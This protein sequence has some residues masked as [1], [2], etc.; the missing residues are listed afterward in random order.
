M[1]KLKEGNVSQEG[2]KEDYIERMYKTLEGGEVTPEFITELVDDFS[3]LYIAGTDTSSIE[4]FMLLYYC[5]SNPKC[6]EKLREEVDEFIK[7]DEDIRED[8]IKKMR[9]LDGVFAETTRMHSPAIGVFPRCVTKDYFMKEVQIKKDT[10]VNASF[11]GTQYNPRIY[12]EPF[13]FRPERWISADGAKLSPKPYTWLTF[14]GGP[15]TCIGRHVAEILMKIATIKIV[16][17]F[18]I[19]FA[20]GKMPLL[21]QGTLY[22]PGETGVTM[23][24]RND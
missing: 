21:L 1:E 7:S 12:D 5:F 22:E 17:N 11:L 23:K 15:R 10:I 8:N 18:D 14:S 9:Y 19:E 13:E 20:P 16:K 2:K 3:L 4:T 6:L 24:R